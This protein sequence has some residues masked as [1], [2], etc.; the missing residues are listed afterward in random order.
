MQSIS[1][2]LRLFGEFA[3]KKGKTGV[4]VPKRTENAKGVV[5]LTPNNKEV[6]Y[7]QHSLRYRKRLSRR[8]E[9]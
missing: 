2:G 3:I 5:I 8:T 9:L 7:V 1:P 6:L 4:P